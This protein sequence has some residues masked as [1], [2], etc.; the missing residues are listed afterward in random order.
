MNDELFKLIGIVILVGFFIYI[1]VKS[2]RLHTSIMEGL[3]NP[4]S[5]KNDSPALGQNLASGA[6]PYA[7][8]INKAYTRMKDNFHFETYRTN[9]ENAI[10]QM[11]DYASALM[12]QKVMS[13]DKNSLTEDNLMDTITKINALGEGKK[14]LNTVMKYIDSV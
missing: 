4:D 6:Q 7:D 14:N 8:E 10:I 9:Y 5:A 2:L 13:L 12:L 11:D 1:V 3:V